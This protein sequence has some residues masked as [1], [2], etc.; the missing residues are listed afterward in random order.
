[1]KD[2]LVIIGHVV[3]LILLY[4]LF[5]LCTRMHV[6]LAVPVMIVGFAV[7]VIL[8]VFLEDIL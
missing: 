4:L 5:A 8:N 6:F 2:W 1:M 7:F 3:L